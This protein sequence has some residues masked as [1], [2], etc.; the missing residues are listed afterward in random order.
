MDDCDAAAWW[1]DRAGDRLTF[2][3]LRRGGETGGGEGATVPELG[4]PPEPDIDDTIA[5]A[6]PVVLRLGDACGVLV[7]LRRHSR[8]LRPLAVDEM[9]TESGSR[10]G[11]RNCVSGG[12]AGLPDAMVKARLWDVDREDGGEA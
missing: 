5:D 8:R 1:P 9:L 7:E 2:E 12:R 4:V 6:S 11:E 3:F 10:T